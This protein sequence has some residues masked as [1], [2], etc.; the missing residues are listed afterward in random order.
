MKL[1]LFGDDDSKGDPIEYETEHRKG[2][3]EMLDI[4]RVE[5]EKSKEKHARLSPAQ[6]REIDMLWESGEVTLTTLSERYGK[7]R[8][9][10]VAHFKKYGV[11][12]GARKDEIRRAAE[13]IKKEAQS[14]EQ[15]VLSER[16]KQTKEDHYKMSEA[17]G[18][19]AFNEIL[20]AR[21]DGKP[22]RTVQQDIKTLL[23][24]AETLKKVREERWITLGLDKD[25]I[26]EETL[27]ELV[28]TTMTQ[29]QCEQLREEQQED[30]QVMGI[31]EED[32][33]V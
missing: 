11:V 7:T 19:L 15:R 17:I 20:K 14:A 29:D 27:P 5:A 10:F 22:F 31:D 25:V 3:K 21:K 24:T 16:I 2:L 4:Q 8:E 32:L 9:C 30:E 18:R 1:F 13:E 28:I 12:K 26:D 6:W 23:L 33:A